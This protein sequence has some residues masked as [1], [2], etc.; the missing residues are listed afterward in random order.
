MDFFSH[1]NEV[2][3]GFTFIFPTIACKEVIATMVIASTVMR[4][5]KFGVK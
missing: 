2:I 1:T 4:L 5:C 3:L